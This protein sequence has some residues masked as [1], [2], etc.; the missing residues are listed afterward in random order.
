MEFV[1]FR[2]ICTFS[3]NFLE[4]STG[5]RYRSQIRHILMKFTLTY[6]S[7]SGSDE[8]NIENIE[9]SLSEILTVYLVDKIRLSVAVTSNKYC[10]FG[11]V[12]GP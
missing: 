10:I 8:R 12:Q 7:D 9:L 2:G 4:F 6:H 3:R 1:S 5:Q 11:P